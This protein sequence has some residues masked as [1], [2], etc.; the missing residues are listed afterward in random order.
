MKFTT[1]QRATF[2]SL[3]GLGAAPLIFGHAALIF[4]PYIKDGGL[5]SVFGRAAILALYFT[6][7]RTMLDLS[8]DAFDFFERRYRTAASPNNDINVG[9]QRE[10]PYDV[11][12]EREIKRD[13]TNWQYLLFEWTFLE[14]MFAGFSF[15]AMLYALFRSPYPEGPGHPLYLSDHAGSVHGIFWSVEVMSGL[16]VFFSLY[17]IGLRRDHGIAPLVQRYLGM[18]DTYPG[19]NTF[20]ASWNELAIKITGKPM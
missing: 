18:P 7:I 13:F 20:P 6:M 8:R 9:R 1:R 2:S 16:L 17:S 4:Q 14:N 19:Q 10:A 11:L 5:T 15:W 3:A 12:T